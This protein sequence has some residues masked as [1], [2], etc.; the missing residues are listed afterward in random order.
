MITTAAASG[1]NTLLASDNAAITSTAAMIPV[2]IFSPKVPILGSLDR[3]ATQASRNPRLSVAPGDGKGCGASL[4]RVIGVTY[5]DAHLNLACFSNLYGEKE[6][7][8][9]VS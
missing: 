8:C 2:V 9:P 6:P 1:A 7:P 4:N 3:P 5:N